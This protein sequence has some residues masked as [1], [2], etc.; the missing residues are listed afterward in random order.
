MKIKEKKVRK[1]LSKQIQELNNIVAD[2]D[3]LVTEIGTG[4]YRVAIFGSARTK[5]NT[6]EYKSVYNLA[7]ELASRGADIVTGGGPGLME[8]ANAGAKEGS[9]QTKSFGL[10]IDLPFEN[11]F[12]SHLDIK[13]FHKKFSSRL[14]EFM[15]ITNAVVVTPGG[16]GTLLE[17][18][19]A[20]QLIQVGHMKKKPIILVGTMWEGL[21]QWMKE[22]PLRKE[23]I[24]KSDLQHI[25]IVEEMED[26]VPVLEKDIKSFYHLNGK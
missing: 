20:W 23:L 16:I 12:N 1:F 15:R 19:F 10:R 26:V 7:K 14:D 18:F 21:I 24:D 4:Y 22:N 2:L 25:Q 6:P 5:P 17:L 11:D 8:A 3:D 13:F 9:S